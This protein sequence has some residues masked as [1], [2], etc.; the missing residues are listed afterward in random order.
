MKRIVVT[1]THQSLHSGDGPWAYCIPMTDT[2]CK[3][4]D[5][6]FEHIKLKA[7]PEDRYFSWG[8]IPVLH[9]FIQTF[10][11][12]FFISEN[13]TILNQRVNIFDYIKSAPKDSKWTHT[14]KPIL[15]TLS[16]KSTNGHPLSGIFMLDCRNKEA[17]TELLNDWWNDLPNNQCKSS[18]PYEQVPLIAWKSI[19]QKAARV[20][21]ADVWSV[22]EF[23]NDQV[24]IQ[25]TSAYKN[26][27]T[28]EAKKYMFRLLND[29][30][31]KIGIFVR[32]NNYYC[33]GAGQNCIFIKH[34][35]E[36]AGY[37]VD[38][39]V[40]Y[41]SSKSSVV[42]TQIPYV[43]TSTKNIKYEDYSFIVYGWYIPTMKTQ[44]QI[45]DLGIRTAIFHPMN[46]FDSLHNDHFIH[47]MESSVPLFEENFYKTAD[48]VWLTQN[49]EVTYKSL[50]EIQNKH[51]IPVRVIPLSWA[52]LFTLYN[53]IQYNYIHND[54]KPI[55]I[56]IMEPNMSYWKSAWLPLVIAEAFYMKHKE[57][58]NKVFLFGSLSKEA[59]AMI[60]TLSIHKD[61]KLR[62]I[63]R[64]PINEILKFFC[65]TEPNKV[66]VISHN[67]QV[68]LNY[69]YYD[70]MNA[71]M[72]FLHN[73]YVLESQKM[74]YMYSNVVEGVAQL[75]RVFSS[76]DSASYMKPIHEVLTS[77]NPYSESVIKVFEKYVSQPHCSV[78]TYII[79]T[80]NKERVEFM[81]QQLKD[82]K[83]PFPYTFF[84]AHRPEKSSD[85]INIDVQSTQNILLACCLRS[86]VSALQ[87]FLTT[88]TSEYVIILEDDIC[89][90]NTDLKKEINSYMNCLENNPDLHYISFSYR[91]YYEDYK[92]I[93]SQLSKLE[94]IEKIYY[95]FNKPESFVIWGS[96]GYIMSRR[97]AQKI[98]DILYK[99]SLKEI[100]TS[101]NSYLTSHSSFSRKTPQL[102]IDSLLPTLLNQ[103]IVYPMLAVETYFENSI[104][105]SDKNQVATKTYRELVNVEY[106][107]QQQQQQQQSSTIYGC[108]VSTMS[109]ERC[110]FMETQF[111]DIQFPYPNSFFK[112]YTKETSIEYFD[113][114]PKPVE[115]ELLLLCMRSHIGAMAM[116]L[117]SSDADYFLIMEDDVAFQTQDL[118]KRIQAVI[119][120]LKRHNL[121]YVSLSYIPTCLDKSQISTKLHLL[122]SDDDV[123]W[124]FEKPDVEFTVWGSQAYIFSRA[125]AQKLVSLLH[126]SKLSE[127]RDKYFTYLK[128]N[129]TYANKVHRSTIDAIL[130]LILNQGILHPMICVEKYFTNSISNS[131]SREKEVAEYCSHVDCKYYPATTIA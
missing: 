70:V 56:I 96:Q 112:A 90:Q 110:E 21:V 69:A 86:H 44:K 50:L 100:V 119:S 126:Y 71:G 77:I 47:N 9:K 46:S 68:P 85:Y 131:S 75:E 76:H 14:D 62:R 87:T 51:K 95:G 17:A 19:P 60:Q 29:K 97:A 52:P 122:T 82:V 101:V 93:E 114:V 12:I 84:D 39:L 78:S 54:S 31:K 104:S 99:P 36:A 92:P 18:Y 40:D 81:K 45:K 13:A 5:F 7:N 11:E 20:Q 73:S 108:I 28:Y 115:P 125:V 3:I 67:I 35:L 10:D 129:K 109:K 59:D 33:S 32:Q 2:Y 65:H 64:M 107:K 61:S 80:Q 49:H 58:L 128:S 83:Y 106:Y 27:Q 63:G 30:Q 53:G 23:D 88:S 34:S 113:V 42:D 94:K 66:A 43:Y 25:L 103:G 111:K 89:F 117:Q 102:L 1:L 6:K 105:F 127:V 79:S 37:R 98:V 15:Y 55:D 24:F 38:L 121:D 123:Y 130:P 72:P 22:Q 91:P 57:K 74:G 26:I 120:K 118:D 8:K 4:H 124:G 116:C 48:E 16:D 41:D